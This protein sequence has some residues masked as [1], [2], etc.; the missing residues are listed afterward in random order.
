MELKVPPRLDE[1][2]MELR[3][4]ERNRK[5]FEVKVLA[6]ADYMDRSM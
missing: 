3:V 6:V 4:L 2:F 5:P 1:L